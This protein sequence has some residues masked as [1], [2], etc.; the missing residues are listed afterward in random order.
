YLIDYVTD[1]SG[2]VIMRAKPAVAGDARAR[3]IDP[4]TVYVMN[5]M[6]QGVATHGTGARASAEL[7]RNDIGGKTGTT[8]DSHDAWFAGYTPDVVGVAWM[9]Y[10]Q[11]R[12]LGTGETGGGVSLPIWVAFMREALKDMEPKTPGHLPDGLERI[13]GDFYFAEYL[14]DTTI[15]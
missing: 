11:P 2:E 4:R 10:D 12:S 6:L 13:E 9:C 1:N 14:P 15:A 5:D 3:A 8:N 7:K